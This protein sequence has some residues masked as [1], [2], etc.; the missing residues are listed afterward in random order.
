[1]EHAMWW[2]VV[3]FAGLAVA[4]ILALITLCGMSRVEFR[5]LVKFFLVYFVAAGVIYFVAI[6]FVVTK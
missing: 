5:M 6:Y 1:M 3:D 4:A 2:Q